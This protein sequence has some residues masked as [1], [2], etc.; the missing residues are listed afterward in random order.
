MG[1]TLSLLVSLINFFTDVLLLWIHI[2][3]SS[4][5]LLLLIEA[6]SIVIQKNNYRIFV[7]AFMVLNLTL[8]V[9]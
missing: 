4:L 6:H 5:K 7:V 1:V 2:L 8:F 3:Y 9:L